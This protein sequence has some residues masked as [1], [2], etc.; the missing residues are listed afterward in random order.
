MRF[1]QAATSV[2]RV[3]KLINPV[4]RGWVNYFAVGHASA[5][6]GFVKDWVEKKIR[7]RRTGRRQLRGGILGGALVGGAVANAASNN[8][9]V[10]TA[11][12]GVTVNSTTCYFTRRLVNP[13]TQQWVR[14]QVCTTPAP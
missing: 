3:V 5:C 6:F 11:E 14:E 13:V 4:L 12:P 10:A 1:H 2:D 9:V 7:P 8:A